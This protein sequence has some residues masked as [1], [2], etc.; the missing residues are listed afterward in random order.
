LLKVDLGGQ[1]LAL[2]DLELV[3]ILICELV[4]EALHEVQ[5]HLGLAQIDLLR[6]KFNALFRG[7]LVFLIRHLKLTI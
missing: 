1:G 7:E 6:H 2:S 5:A 4:L 3:G